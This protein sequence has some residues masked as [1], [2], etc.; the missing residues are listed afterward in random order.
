MSD[1]RKCLQCDGTGLLSFGV[2]QN[3]Q[4]TGVDRSL[5]PAAQA[6]AMA[7]QDSIRKVTE[8]NAE[9]SDRLKKWQ[10]ELEKVRK[11]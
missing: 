9:L 8:A 7:V 1:E 10:V 2:C 11:P 6:A 3:C 4:G 5:F